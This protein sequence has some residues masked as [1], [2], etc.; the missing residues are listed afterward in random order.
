[1]T[2][3]EFVAQYS[4]DTQGRLRAE[5]D[6]RISPALKTTYG[7]D[8]EGHVT[9]VTAPGQQPWL[10]HYGTLESDATPGRLL[11]VT[12][13]DASTAFG[14]G[15]APVNAE[16]PK[17]STKAPTVGTEMTV[18]T[19]TWSYSP[20]SY[21]YQWEDCTGSTCAVIPGATNQGYTP[22]YGDEGKTLKVLVTA[23]NDAGSATI[24]SAG[25]RVEEQT[26]FPPTYDLS[27]GSSESK[28]GELRRPEYVAVGTY[29]G[30]T[31]VFVTD[32][33][34]NAVDEFSTSGVYEGALEGYFK[35]P[36]GIAVGL[37]EKTG[38]L[39]VANS[40][41]KQVDLYID[42]GALYEE[43][44]TTA[45][46]ALGGV[47]SYRFKGYVAD[48]GESDLR[49]FEFAPAAIRGIFGKA[50]SG[51]GEFK[52]PADLVESETGGLD[53]PDTG[54]NRV[55]CFNASGVEYEGKFGEAGSGNGQ[56]KAPKGIALDSKDNIWVADTGN[57]RV[58]IFANGACTTKNGY[59]TQFG[60]KGSGAGEFNEPIG[61]AF[62]PS[63]DIYVV[64]SGNDRVQKWIPGVKPASPPLPPAKPP[65][66]SGSSVTT[67][68]YHIP[69]SGT[70]LPNVT[71][72][73]VT[74][75]GQKDDPTEG[76]AVFPPDEPMGWPASSYKRAT[77]R[78]WDAEGR[79]VDTEVPSGGIATSEYNE[80]NDVTRTL[81]ADNRAAALK[82]TGK[83]AEVAEKLDTKSTYSVGGSEL[84]ETIGPEHEVKV[85]TSNGKEVKAGSEVMG[86]DHVKYYY[87]EGAKEV[88]EKT[89]ETYEFGDE[90]G[91]LRRNREQRKVRRTRRRRPRTR[92]RKTL[93]G[94]CASRRR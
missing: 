89:H 35:E 73:E 26:M 8:P 51:N 29:E 93:A 77:I 87:D 59:I 83:T 56:F 19:G 47:A 33:G 78:Y 55:Q 75:W 53:V 46:G 85:A 69:T 21:S 61:V 63:G 49:S 42:D 65:T 66:V 90:D 43:A 81:S 15:I 28:G 23:T 54:N 16:V 3:E 32:T 57:D 6:P 91:R 5:W 94:N 1:M 62:D 30:R 34:A 38:R 79:T 25:A 82:E 2:K 7:Y 60:S 67:I 70:G 86:R 64:D 10:L 84:L 39:Y 40:G 45:T 48:S 27:F 4:Y 31:T 71:E 50:G 76:V 36:T 20:L 14:E 44:T 80:D 24:V 17:P 11:S 52:E 41:Y 58:E 9:A 72:A 68:E 92:A 13:P 88:E 18:S 74:K 12:R 22:R 37:V